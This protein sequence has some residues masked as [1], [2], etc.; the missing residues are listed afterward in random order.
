VKT[1]L[2]FRVK[3]W[4]SHG[5]PWRLKSGQRSTKRVA[6]TIKKCSFIGVPFFS[7]L[8]SKF[9]NCSKSLVLKRKIQSRSY[10]RRHFDFTDTRIHTYPEFNAV[11]CNRLTF[12]LNSKAIVEKNWESWYWSLQMLTR[13]F[14]PYLENNGPVFLWEFKDQVRTYRWRKEQTRTGRIIPNTDRT[15][16]LLL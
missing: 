11:R 10:C 14:C 1:S 13:S 5:R 9:I 16:F 12:H 2:N 3:T 8:D 15:K 6:I 7:F 4:R